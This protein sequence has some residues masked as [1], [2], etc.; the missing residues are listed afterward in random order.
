MRRAASDAHALALA[1][2]AL[3][4]ARVRDAGSYGAPQRVVDVRG[5]G[6]HPE[7]GPC[8][9]NGARGA[10]RYLVGTVRVLMF[11]DIVAATISL[12]AATCPLYEVD[13]MDPSF[14][15]AQLGEVVD[16]LF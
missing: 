5:R 15:E 14:A 10:S 3:R 4:Q 16:M 8:W 13:G 2:W 7:E 6:H 9:R 12:E 1:C 11:C